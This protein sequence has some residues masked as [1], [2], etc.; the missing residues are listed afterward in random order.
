MELF[1]RRF[2]PFRRFIRVDGVPKLSDIVML[3]IV[4]TNTKEA[5][6]FEQA[7][8]TRSYT[9][10]SRQDVDLSKDEK[11]VRESDGEW[12]RLTTRGEDTATSPVCSNIRYWQAQAVTHNPTEEEQQA[13]PLPPEEPE[14]PVEPPED[15]PEPEAVRM[16]YQVPVMNDYGYYDYLGYFSVPFMAQISTVGTLYTPNV[17]TQPDNLNIARGAILRR[18]SD[19]SFLEVTSEPTGLA[20]LAMAVQPTIPANY[21]EYGVPMDWVQFRHHFTARNA[22]NVLTYYLSPPFD[23]ATSKTGA[24]RFVTA[25]QGMWVMDYQTEVFKPLNPSGIIRREIGELWYNV[26][27]NEYN[28]SFTEIEGTDLRWSFLSTYN[29]STAIRNSILL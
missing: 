2:V 23:V 9:V 7:I 24:E 12:I 11:F 29:P 10:I 14:P 16:Y 5:R 18:E 20:E 13:V 1:E 6:L 28:Y 3:G 17:P 25:Y 26:Y 4:T 21:E 27:S 19:M 15:R 22:S 8:D